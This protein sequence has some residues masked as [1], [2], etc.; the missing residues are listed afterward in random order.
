MKK[1]MMNRISRKKISRSKMKNC[2]TQREGNL[3]QRLSERKKR[4]PVMMD[5]R[6][7]RVKYKLKSGSSDCTLWK[8]NVK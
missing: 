2:E 7:K 3:I 4:A 1:S 5:V 6:E 8:D